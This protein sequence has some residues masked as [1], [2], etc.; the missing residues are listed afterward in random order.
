MSSHAAAPG[1]DLLVGQRTD[2]RCGSEG[3]PGL[4]ILREHDLGRDRFGGLDGHRRIDGRLRRGSERLRDLV[5]DLRAAGVVAPDPVHRDQLVVLARVAQGEEP[6]RSDQRLTRTAFAGDVHQR[7]GDTRGRN[8]ETLLHGLWLPDPAPERDLCRHGALEALRL[9]RAGHGADR[10]RS[11]CPARG[12]SAFSTDWSPLFTTIFHRA[13]TGPALSIVL[14]RLDAVQVR[15][16][17]RL[18][19]A[20]DLGVGQWA[21]RRCRND[22]LAGLV[23]DDPAG[24]RVDRDGLVLR[25]ARRS[26]ALGT[27]RG[28]GGDAAEDRGGGDDRCGRGGD[29][30]LADRAP[31]T[32]ENVPDVGVQRLV[33]VVGRGG[34]QAFDVGAHEA[35]LS[36]W[37]SSSRR[38][39]RPREVW[40]F[41]PPTLMPRM[42]AVCSRLRSA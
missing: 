41:T 13:S 31:G 19:T 16:V 35:L 42:S 30:A 26:G 4:R 1:G 40:L 17:V 3:L 34:Q 22:C 36:V 21:H 2:R 10:R 20:E 38:R 32:D 29:P 8:P 7:P 14:V 28:P 25:R 39:P 5:V 12:S 37:S 18:A 15:G 27:R 23:V 6:V 24:L 9:L 11:T 33:R